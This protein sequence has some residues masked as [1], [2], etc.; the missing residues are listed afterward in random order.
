MNGRF[1]EEEMNRFEA[2]L[3]PQNSFMPPRMFLPSQMRYE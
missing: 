2:E 1:I 3:R